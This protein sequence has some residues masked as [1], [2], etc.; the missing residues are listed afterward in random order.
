VF[1]QRLPEVNA[2]FA[3]REHHTSVTTLA[4]SANQASPR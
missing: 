1:D 3:M 2:A 4:P